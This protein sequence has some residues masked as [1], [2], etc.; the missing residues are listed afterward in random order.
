MPWNSTE[1]MTTEKMEREH[2]R[3]LNDDAEVYGRGQ[4]YHHFINSLR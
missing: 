1:P 2:P 3:C 4:G